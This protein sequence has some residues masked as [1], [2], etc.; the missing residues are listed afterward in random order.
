MATKKLLSTGDE[1]LNIGQQVFLSVRPEDI[2]L[3]TKK[4]TGNLEANCIE[5]SVIETVYLGNFLECRVKIGSHEM[6]VQIDHFEQLDPGQTVHV[7]FLPQHG[8]TLPN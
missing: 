1:I 7:S 6:I 8:L 5:G 3:S 2:K 4:F